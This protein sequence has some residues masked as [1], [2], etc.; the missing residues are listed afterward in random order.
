LALKNVVPHEHAQL[1]RH[2][3]LNAQLYHS[4]LSGDVGLVVETNYARR[5][6]LK[7]GWRWWAIRWAAPGAEAGRRVGASG[8]RCAVFAAVCPAIDLA[9]GADALQRGEPPL[10]SGIFCA[11]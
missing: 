4:G 1:R 8:R 6:K 2:E 7:T 9:P 11:A 5:F 10:T 3:S